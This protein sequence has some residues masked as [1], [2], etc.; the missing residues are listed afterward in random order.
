M[1]LKGIDVLKTAGVEEKF[2]TWVSVLDPGIQQ[3][4]LGN[5]P[6]GERGW[7]EGKGL[8]FPPIH[9]HLVKVVVLQSE[10]RHRE[11]PLRS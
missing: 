1:S 9:G 7:L 3:E 5:R 8:I 4:K 2:P 10:V 6:K 11:F